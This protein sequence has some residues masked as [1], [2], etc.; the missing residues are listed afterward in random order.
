MTRLF[1]TNELRKVFSLDGSWDFTA[2]KDDGDSLES[3]SYPYKLT[4][5]GCWEMHPEFLT[6]RGRGA[7]RK[8]V[9]IREKTAL[10]FVFKGVSHT[11]R[12]YF[13]GVLIAEHYNAYTAFHAIVNEVEQGEHEL[14][15]LV[16][17]SFGEFS[18]LHVPNDYYT[19]GGINR[20]VAMEE[21]KD[22]YVERIAFTPIW[23]NGAWKA[24]VQAYIHKLNNL[25]LSYRLSFQLNGKPYELGEGKLQSDGETMLS[26]IFDFPE[27]DA[28]SPESPKLYELRMKLIVEGKEADDLIE[29]V[30]FRV[31]TTANGKIQLNGKDIV[32]KGVNRHEDHPMVGSAIPLQ[33]MALDADL[34][35]DM[36]CNAV[37]TSH[38]PSDERFL[39]LCD[40]RG[41]LVWEENHAR[42]LS[43]EQMSNPNFRW[44]CE[45]VNRE[46]V[47]QHHNHPSIVIWAILNECASNTAKGREMYKEQLEQIRAL[48]ASRPLTFASHHRESELCFDLADIV[49]FNL[50]PGWYGDEDPGELCDLARGWADAKGGLGKPMIMSEFGGDGYYGHRDASRVRGTEERQ[51]DIIEANLS[52][53][54]SRSFISGM[55]IWQYCDCRVT[56]GTDWLITR[57]GTQ[58]SKGIVDRYRRPKL[59]YATVQRYF[60]KLDKSFK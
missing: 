46:M 13:D 32:F 22:Q 8:R 3:I 40:E 18:A 11:A 14:V 52:A 17:N 60:K 27:V 50:Y 29:R 20:P 53:Y 55:F 33:L 58:N 47:E 57:A 59:A 36:G 49:S 4:V 12:V 1:Q 28:W 38:Y 35:T 6:Y 5:P 21:I 15:V 39:D 10:R 41:I 45:Q 24:S 56:E 16:D 23:E 25:E 2:I 54:T 43:L 48:D 37:R 9:T 34:M 19:Y 51:A 44:Q 7:Y 31:V 30:G 26:G 42:G